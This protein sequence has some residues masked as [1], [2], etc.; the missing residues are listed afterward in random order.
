MSK[1]VLHGTALV[2]IGVAVAGSVSVCGDEIVS[3]PNIPF[4]ARCGLRQQ[5]A[6]LKGSSVDLSPVADPNHEHQQQ[7][8]L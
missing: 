8:I 5:L 4:R 3:S 7:G 1:D 2:G 6:K